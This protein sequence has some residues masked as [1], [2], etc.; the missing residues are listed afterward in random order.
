[1]ANT[2]TTY[3][4][5]KGLN[6]DNYLKFKELFQTERDDSPYVELIE[7]F[8][9]LFGEKFNNSDNFFGR[10]WMM[11]NIGSKSIQIEFGGIEYL[12]EIDLIIESS[13]SVP[14]EYIQKVRDVLTEWD[15]DITLSGTYEDEGYSPIGAFVYAFD[16]DDIEDYDEVDGERMWVDDDYNEEIYDDLYSLRDDLYEAYLEVKKEREEDDR[17]K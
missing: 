5:I 4:K 17:N 2:M 16:Y 15:K 1:M 7:H 11:N 10:E 13:W 14:T 6:E 9:K 3:V 8:N 12:P